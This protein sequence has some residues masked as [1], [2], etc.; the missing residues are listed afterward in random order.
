MIILI[1]I[2]TWICWNPVFSWQPKR[3]NFLLHKMI[4]IRFQT[5]FYKF[6]HPDSC[7]PKDCICRRKRVHLTKIY[8]FRALGAVVLSGDDTDWK[9]ISCFVMCVCVTMCPSNDI[10]IFCFLFMRFF[11]YTKFISC[12]SLCSMKIV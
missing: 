11:S 9:Y 7:W 1:K 10:Y 12:L 4:E 2:Q 5:I 8:L 3:S 6:M